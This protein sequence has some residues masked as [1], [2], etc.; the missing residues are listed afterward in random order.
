MVTIADVARRAGVSPKTVSNVLNGYRYLRPETKERVER[1]I[2]ELGYTVNLA[3]RGLRRGR[4]GMVTLAMP[5]LRDP[6]LAELSGQIIHAAEREGGRVL[7]TQTDGRRERELEVLHG[8]NRHF[9]DGT[10]LSPQALG[11]Q[12]MGQY[13]VD[14]PLVLLGERVDPP[15]IDRVTLPNAAAAYALTAYVLGLGCRRVVLLG[16]APGTDHG[17]A[18]LREQGFRAAHADMGVEIDENLLL[19]ESTWRLPQ[20]TQRMNALIDSGAAFD[21]VVA[22]NDA[23]AIGALHSFRAHDIPVPGAVKVVGIDNIEDASF[24]SPT[25]T[26]LSVDHGEFAREAVR[27]LLTRIDEHH[28]DPDLPRMPRELIRPAFRIEVR[29]STGG[30]PVDDAVAIG[31]GDDRYGAGGQ[32]TVR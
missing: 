8:A 23:L 26:S 15:D 21:A 25:L 6:Y 22:M 3:A 29:Q 27:L 32:S 17:S 7:V 4:T 5:D 10:I 14:F 28:R 20:G 30:V 11:P 12:D 19:T 24:T 1:A 9:T 31:S 16:C 2:R 18:P 13:E